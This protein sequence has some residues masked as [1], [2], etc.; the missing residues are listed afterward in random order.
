M[1][2]QSAPDSRR[3]RWRY[4]D[5]AFGAARPERVDL[6]ELLFQQYASCPITH[7]LELGC[8]TG[9]WLAA[10]GQRGYVMTGMDFDGVA[11]AMAREKCRGIGL[12]VNLIKQHLA[13]WT[14][15]CSYDA[16]IAPNNTLKW[17]PN[18]NSLRRCIAQ[19]AL[20]LRPGGVLILDLTFAEELWRYCDWG[21]AD[22]LEKHA[23][24]SKFESSS[25]SGEYRCFYGLPNL[26]KGTIPF[27]ERFVCQD[28][29]EK[30]ILE[31]K[32]AWLLFSAEE[33]A[34]W[35]LEASLLE[36]VRFYDRGS[37]VPKEIPQSD[38]RDMGG[39]CLLVCQR[40]K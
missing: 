9:R 17:L 29:G 16:V 22:H 15:D 21:T 13:S 1:T 7:I 37:D 11:L 5:L 20:A 40:R 19:T 3:K 30:V 4:Y 2:D 31:N 12:H 18:H 32:T 23:W 34:A 27:I 39:Q 28:H 14:P 36:N 24:T 35:V 10:L 8:G 26:D 38:L 6:C 25:V 33:F